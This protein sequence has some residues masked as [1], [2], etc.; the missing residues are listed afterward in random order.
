MGTDI[1]VSLSACSVALGGLA[2]IVG[3]QRFGRRAIAFGIV[4]AIAEPLFVHV[5]AR[6]EHME[7]PNGSAWLERILLALFLA[8]V[9]IAGLVA[10]RK[11]RGGKAA[12]ATSQKKRVERAP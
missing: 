11:S 8:A 12:E 3:A 4:L 10:L 7:V 6:L 2:W 9:V 5:I 1:I